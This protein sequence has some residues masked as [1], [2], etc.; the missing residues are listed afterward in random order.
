MKCAAESRRAFTPATVGIDAVKVARSPRLAPLAIILRDPGSISSVASFFDP[1]SFS[2]GRRGVTEAAFRDD[3]IAAVRASR[4]A[5]RVLGH[6]LGEDRRAAR[7]PGGAPY[8]PRRAG[9]VPA[10]VQIHPGDAGVVIF[11]RPAQ[12][13]FELRL[14][15]LHRGRVLLVAWGV[16]GVGP[17]CP[18]ARPIV[19]AWHYTCIGT[20]QSK[21]CSDK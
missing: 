8:E 21:M 3:D 14:P 12:R 7:E 2:W 20:S 18:R 19:V 6:H 1:R 4:R 16:L 17:L 15:G 13:A 9:R 11:A 5:G 10:T